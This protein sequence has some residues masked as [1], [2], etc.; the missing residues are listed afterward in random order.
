MFRTRR[1]EFVENNKNENIIIIRKELVVEISKIQGSDI[2]IRKR[3]CDL[4]IR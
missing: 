3:A 1:N 4:E 2:L